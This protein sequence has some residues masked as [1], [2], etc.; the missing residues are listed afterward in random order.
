[1]NRD[2]LKFTRA[3]HVVGGIAYSTKSRPKFSIEGYY[4]LY[5]NYPFLL[6]EQI[7]L[8][9]LGADFGVIGNVPISSTGQGR[10]YGLEVLVQQRLYKGFYGILAY[11]LGWSEF[12]DGTGNYQ[13]SAWDSRHIVNL[14]LGK[15]FNT[16]NKAIKDKINVKRIEQG[17]KERNSKLTS[18]TLDIGCNLRMQTG[19][20]FT[21]FDQVG[22]ALTSNW[23]RFRQGILD[24]DQLNTQRLGLNYSVDVRVDYKWF[25]PKWS[26]NLYL[27]IQNIPGVVTGTSSL[28]LDEDANGNPQIIDPGTPQESYK[29]KSIAGGAGTIV[30][31]LGIIVQY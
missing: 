6:N 5:D 12:K 11:T 31:T 16:M 22:S 14:A 25:F 26:F 24:Y 30:P 9:N 10:T 17:K 4:K 3:F 18:Q 7:S 8:A 21:P 13:P 19:L 15:T 28:I 20:P 29:L 23:N 27:D 2:R 1:V